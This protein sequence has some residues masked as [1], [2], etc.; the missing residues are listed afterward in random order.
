MQVSSFAVKLVKPLV[1]NL[2]IWAG[3]TGQKIKVKWTLKLS[4]DKRSDTIFVKRYL[5]LHKDPGYLF[6][7]ATQIRTRN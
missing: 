5:A 4:G 1:N 6:L 3:S 7:E 2:N